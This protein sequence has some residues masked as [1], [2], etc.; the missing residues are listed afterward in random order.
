VCESIVQKKAKKKAR[1]ASE[2]KKTQNKKGRR[3]RR[4]SGLQSCTGAGIPDTAG[5]DLATIPKG[6]KE[7]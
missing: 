4:E 5:R 1:T 7:Y 6:E 3:R 2:K